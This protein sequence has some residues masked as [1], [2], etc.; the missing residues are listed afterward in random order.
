MIC[1]IKFSSVSASCSMFVA[2]DKRHSFWSALRITRSRHMTLFDRSSQR[3][4]RRAGT[5][6]CPRERGSSRTPPCKQGCP[7]VYPQ[8]SKKISLRTCWSHLLHFNEAHSLAYYI[9]LLILCEIWC[10]HF[11]VAEHAG[12]LGCVCGYVSGSRHRKGS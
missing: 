6:P 8:P 4:E 12:L 11:G 2:T 3:N 7:K 5:I 10:S 9:L 1:P